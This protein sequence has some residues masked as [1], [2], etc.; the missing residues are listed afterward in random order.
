MINRYDNNFLS[1]GNSPIIRLSK[2]D[3]GLTNRIYAK[4]EF[5]N[6]A[7]SVKDRIGYAMIVDAIA[8]ND[9]REKMEILEPTSG[10]TGIALAMVGASYGYSVNLV[11]P[12][13]MSEER[14]KLIKMLGANLILTPK[15]KGIIGS[16][17][18]VKKMIEE[19]PSKYFVPGQFSNPSNP[20][21]HEAT[22]GPEIFRD[23]A[24][25]VDIFVACVGTGGTITGV[26]KYLK[27]VLDE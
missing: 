18:E 22:T 24:G 3:K 20:K 7:F 5:R 14:K 4:L 26:S 1:F 6:P 17:N 2:I 12:E 13:S 19:S 16:I 10:N 27:S 25:N 11:M 8:R 21:I 15:E 23:M 9:L